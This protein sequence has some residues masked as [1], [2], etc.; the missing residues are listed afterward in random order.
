MTN[1]QRLEDVFDG[2]TPD[3]LPLLHI[4]GDH[5]GYAE[6]VIAQR[7][8]PGDQ[9]QRYLQ[10]LRDERFAVGQKVGWFSRLPRSGEEVEGGARRYTQGALKPG[11]PLE[12]FEQLGDLDELASLCRHA[13]G[14]SRP[15]GLGVMGYITNCVHAVAT[16]MGWE[17]FALTAYDDPDWLDQ[18]LEQAERYNRRGLE[19]MLAEGVDV[20]LFDGDCAYRSGLLMAPEMMRRWWFGRTKKT[21]DLCRSSGCRAIFHSDGKAD[22]LLPMLIEMGFDGFHGC[23]KQA[24]DLAELKRHFGDQITLVGN[25]DHSELTFRDPQWIAQETERMLAVGAPGGRYVPDV[26]TLVPDCAV[27]NYAAFHETIIRLTGCGC[28]A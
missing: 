25:A 23:E 8:Y 22:D 14:A 17:A 15:H 11:A 3:C 1:W 12:P 7:A 10:Y 9:E 26:N 4:W 2:K 16:A 20:V 18:A 13:C 5:G 21:L 19:V 27:E 28:I 24:N 6:R